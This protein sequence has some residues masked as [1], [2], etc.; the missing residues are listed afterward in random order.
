MAAVAIAPAMAP[1]PT[2]RISP[3][4]NH[5]TQPPRRPR[6]G[7]APAAGGYPG[8]AAAR[9]Y[10]G[11]RWL[12]AGEDAGGPAV[13]RAG[14]GVPRRWRGRRPARRAAAVQPAGVGHAHAPTG[15]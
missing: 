9:R 11:R 6:T 1:R 5:R 15:R 14:G 8:V 12:V 2:V 3:M 4:A 10:G 7:S 13:D